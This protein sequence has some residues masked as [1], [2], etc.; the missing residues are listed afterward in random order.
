MTGIPIKVFGDLAE[1]QC[2][3]IRDEGEVN[4]HSQVA[5][6]LEVINEEGRRNVN[7]EYQ[8][9]YYYYYY[10]YYYFISQRI[11]EKYLLNN[12]FKDHSVEKLKKQNKL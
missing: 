11:L 10:Y 4:T 12:W 5:Y 3:V 8:F 6:P 9:G 2:N 7:F 1:K